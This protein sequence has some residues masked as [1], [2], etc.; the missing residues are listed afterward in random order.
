M[1]RRV[2]LPSV[3]VMDSNL[4]LAQESLRLRRAELATAGDPCVADHVVTGTGPTVAA[5][6]RAALS[7]RRAEH[8]ARRERAL[9]Y[10]QA[11]SVT[12]ALL[13]E[14]LVARCR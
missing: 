10:T 8:A 12:P 14:L 6:L 4:A 7:R 1:W 2:C 9:A 13:Q 5:R 11:A 3:R